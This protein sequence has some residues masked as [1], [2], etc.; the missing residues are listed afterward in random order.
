MRSI[1][2]VEDE[3]TQLMLMEQIVRK[4]LGMQALSTTRGLK[5]LSMLEE[6][7]LPD[8]MLLDMHLPDMHGMD[9]IQEVRKRRIPIPIIIFSA[10]GDNKIAIEAIHAGADDFL[11]KPISVQRLR[12]SVNQ[13]LERAQ[14]QRELKRLER[15]YE[16]CVQFD[17]MI[18]KSPAFREVMKL[19]EHASGSSINVL[20]YGAAGVGKEFLARAIHGSSARNSAPFIVLNCAAVSER[21]FEK[22][23]CGHYNDAS[24]SRY[25]PRPGKIMQAKKGTLYLDGVEALSMGQQALLQQNMPVLEE[26]DVRVIASTSKHL[27]SWVE[28]GLFRA[29]LYFKINGMRITLP[30]LSERKEDIALLAEDRMRGFAS[31]EKKPV[32]H[33]SPAALE[34]MES[35]PWPGNIDQLENTLHRAVIL[36]EGDTL[37]KRHFQTSERDMEIRLERCKDKVNGYAKVAN[38]VGVEDIN[39]TLVRSDGDVRPMQDVETEAIIYAL[40]HYQGHISRTARKLGIGRSTLYRKIRDLG[41]EHEVQKQ[42]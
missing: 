8:L 26:H 40:R 21:G 38:D 10:Y 41:L 20:L 14:M 1:L 36:C 35:A 29:D 22:V 27:D 7:P 12:L 17:D 28:E 15:H 3:R 11:Y 31:R 39:L 2:I 13:A 6:G 42:G 18:G 23:L 16:N 19:G 37:E 34:W 30:C 24:E 25:A 32:Q 33:I 4:E 5:A 9:V